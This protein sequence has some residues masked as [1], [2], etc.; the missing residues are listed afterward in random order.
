MRFLILTQ[1]F[2]PEPGAAQVRLA[3]FA[4]QLVRAGHEVEIV[5]AMPNY[6]MGR[7]LDGYRRSFYR[8]EQWDGIPTHRLWLYP[9]Q[10]AGLRRMLN[11]G[12]FVLTSLV[13]LA[14]SRKPDYLFVESPPLFLSVPGFLAARLWGVPWIFNVAD[15]W[16]DSVAEMQLLHS[17]WLLRAA[18]VLEKWTY[19][20]A[21][22][23]SAVTWAIRQQLRTEKCVPQEKVLFLP[24]G[25]D[26][27]LFRPLPPDRGLLRRLGLEDKQ[28][29]I[30]PGTHGYAHSME[31]ILQA[32]ERLRHDENIHFLL[33]GSGSA[34]PQLMSAAQKLGLRNMTFLDPV[35]QEEIPQF[36]SIACCGLVSMRDI[37]LLQD[38]RP[39]KALAIM[40]CGK[41][42]ILAVG[43]GSGS[44]V[45]QA[46][47]GL[48]VPV[49]EPDAIA[50]AIRYLVDHPANATQLGC[51][52][53]SYV[54]QNL[55]WP[56]LV[57]EWLGQLPKAA[58]AA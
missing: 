24:N 16:P 53:R 17:G 37:P 1:Y 56:R 45:K 52:A 44:F 9:S 34:K 55:Q 14:K 36:I 38:A 19:R 15:L 39:V 12:S 43:R 32:A 42:V 57:D 4:Q 35:P 54:C 30:F 8:F 11:Y 20:H 3:A 25:I 21:T 41:P 6:P 28:V 48:V 40:G 47:A 27:E 26:T 5:T 46:Q 10:G 58:Q 51:N 18:S 49:D 7:I 29:V 23:V 22:Y 13:G 33:V 31:S 50:G 2:A